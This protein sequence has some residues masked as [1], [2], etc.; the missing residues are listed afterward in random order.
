MYIVK[1][2]RDTSNYFAIRKN[3]FTKLLKAD[4]SPCPIYFAYF[5]NLLI[6]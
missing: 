2:Y 4:G 1:P 6:V 5:S 3:Q